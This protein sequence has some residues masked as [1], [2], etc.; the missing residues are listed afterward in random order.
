MGT[1][2][3]DRAWSDRFIPTMK[4]IIGPMLLEV[5]DDFKDQ[6]QAADLV[7][8][9][10]V[11]R[12]DIACRI[13]RPG[14]ADRYPGEFTVWSSRA[15]GVPT[16]L[17][18]ITDG[19]GDWLFYGHAADETSPAIARW[20]IVNLV[21]FRAHLIRQPSLRRTAMSEMSNRDGGSSFIAV[22]VRKFPHYPALPLLVASSHENLLG[23]AA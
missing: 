9:S 2:R 20:F 17:S 5:S 11:K 23:D 21:S 15:S 8:L 18:K 1:Y 6:K 22:D 13:R 16:E 3:E 12:L 4:A 7:I 14:F 10:T 19:W